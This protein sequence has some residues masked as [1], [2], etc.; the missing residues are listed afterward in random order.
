MIDRLMKKLSPKAEQRLQEI[1]EKQKYASELSKA[2][3]EQ[4]ER[5]TQLI[6]DE[7]E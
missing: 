4:L 2:D 6:K 3:R 1:A 5:I 7:M